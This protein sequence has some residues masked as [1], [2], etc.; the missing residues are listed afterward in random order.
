MEDILKDDETL[1]AYLL[2]DVPLT[3]SVVQQLVNSQ[4]RPEQVNCLN[5]SDMESI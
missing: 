4:I 2:R 3:E 5:D 1:T